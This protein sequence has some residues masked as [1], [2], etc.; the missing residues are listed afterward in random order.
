ML[1]KKLLI[2]LSICSVTSVHAADT[3]WWLK[4]TIC[5]QNPD[6]CYLS[7]GIGYDS[8]YW[9]SE[10]K[11]W[12]MK[13]V[14]DDSIGESSED[15]KVLL[16]IKKLT[17][18]QEKNKD[19]DFTQLNTSSR[20]FGTR[21]TKD[22]GTKAM[23]NGEY[24]KV[25]CTGVL[26]SDNVRVANGEIALN[27]KGAGQPTCRDLADNG[28]L[29]ILNNNKCYGKRYPLPNYFI[30]CDSEQEANT[31]VIVLNGNTNY[32][33]NVSGTSSGNYPVKADKAAQ[34]FDEMQT[35]AQKNHYEKFVKGRAE[36]L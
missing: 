27:Y 34:V 8:G 25:F 11:C 23:V 30:E 6:K 13:Y 17:E 21:K 22:G 4:D 14:C 10:N 9:D 35:V 15:G 18:A 16:S 26:D 20:C 7:M 2:L 36:A 3:E 32:V 31:R 5:R 19:F 1:M 12:G 24:V 29:N 33:A 28:W